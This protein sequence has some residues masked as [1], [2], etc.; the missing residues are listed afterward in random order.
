M[1][2]EFQW[3]FLHFGWHL[4]VGEQPQPPLVSPRPPVMIEEMNELLK[5]FREFCFIIC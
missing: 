5:I 4:C 2:F 1:E 3:Q